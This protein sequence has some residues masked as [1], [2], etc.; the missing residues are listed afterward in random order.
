MFDMIEVTSMSR[1]DENWEFVDSQGHR[2]RW[3]W[4]DGQRKYRASGATVPTCVWVKGETAMDED[5]F[6]V[7]IGGY[8]ACAQCGEKVMPG[9]KADE[10]RVFVRGLQY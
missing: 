4:P 5:G 3:E 8:T 6:E 7:E 10:Q 9:R 2:H 1:P